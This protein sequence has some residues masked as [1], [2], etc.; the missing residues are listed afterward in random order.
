MIK[1]IIPRVEFKGPNLIKGLEFEGNRCI[2]TLEYTCNHYLQQNETLA[3]EIFYYDIVASLY[4]KNFNFDVFNKIKL[5]SSIPVTFCGGFQNLLDIEKALEYGADKISINSYLFKD[6]GFLKD[7]VQKYG[8][9][10]IISN[11]EYYDDGNKYILLTEYGRTKADNDIRDWIL[12][13][14]ENGVGEINLFDVKK[15]GYGE[16]VDIDSINELSKDIRVPF[17]V[18]C[19]YGN[20]DHVYDV[21]KH[22]DCSGVSI[23]SLFH[24][25]INEKVNRNFASYDGPELRCGKDID[26]GNIEFIS[27]GYG[28][29][30][31]LFVEPSTI[32]E[33]KE[34]LFAKNISVR[35]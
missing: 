29:F 11:I 5:L 14:Q 30:K 24:Y 7:A 33:L 18:G 20:K 13:L 4:E 25:S 1:R 8:T 22:T 9:P 6:M 10:T 26:S 19:G 17:I 32:K 12:E 28:G 2:G 27:N 23:A 34:Y 21:L 15:D 35:I 3:D 31:D 16:G